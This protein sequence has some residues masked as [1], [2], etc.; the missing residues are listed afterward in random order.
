MALKTVLAIALAAAAPAALA[1]TQY[2]QATSGSRLSCLPKLSSALDQA[3]Q[4]TLDAIVATK[5]IASS[6]SAERRLS[7]PVGS[8][9]VLVWDRCT[10]PDTGSGVSANTTTSDCAINCRSRVVLNIAGG[11]RKPDD[12][13]FA[14]AFMASSNVNPWFQPF[15]YPEAPATQFVQVNEYSTAAVCESASLFGTVLSNASNVIRVET[16]PLW[17]QC[18]QLNNSPLYL[19]SSLSNSVIEHRLCTDSACSAN[20]IR[21]TVPAAL[22]PSKCGAS[23]AA[24]PAGAV[25]LV[26]GTFASTVPSWRNRPLITI[27][28]IVVSV[29]I[30]AGVWY[31]FARILPRRL[32]AKREAMSAA[33]RTKPTSRNSADI[34]TPASQQVQASGRASAPMQAYQRVDL[35]VYGDGIVDD[36][37]QMDA[38][39]PMA[40]IRRKAQARERRRIEKERAEALAAIEAAN[41]ADAVAAVAA[42]EAAGSVAAPS[43]AVTKP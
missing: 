28:A 30:G 1:Q 43:P 15:Y 14:G 40:D 20:C 34:E 8:S 24:V 7:C 33:E 31:L 26:V 4:D 41:A 13:C 17:S 19:A 36:S 29:I 9:Q 10:G 27:I 16:Y 39:F 23:P 5:D 38:Y 21:K 3:A 37:T 35:M 42:A 11:I 25:R 2:A 6:V 22:T 32:R 12:G 18:T